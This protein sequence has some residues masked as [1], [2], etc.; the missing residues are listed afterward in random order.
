MKKII[1]LGFVF[2]LS[3]STVFG[4]CVTPLLAE[5]LETKICVAPQ[6][7]RARLGETFNIKVNITQAENVYSLQFKLSWDSTVLRIVDVKLKS[8][9]RSEYYGRGMVEFSE[10]MEGHMAGVEV[11]NPFSMITVRIFPLSGDHFTVVISRGLSSDFRFSHPM[12]YEQVHITETNL[13]LTDLDTRFR[14]FVYMTLDNDTDG[15]PG[16]KA[17]F[18][19]FRS[20]PQSMS[21]G[22]FF[23]CQ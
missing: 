15:Q 20:Q 18:E 3:L 22:P 8:T 5:N 16:G 9:F 4:S 17:G 1:L 12:V 21:G 10:G 6:T 13:S 23:T 11:L 14:H 19:I 2:V 7:S